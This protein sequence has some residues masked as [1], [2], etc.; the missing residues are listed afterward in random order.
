[1]SAGPAGEVPDFAGAVLCGGQSRR[2]GRDKALIPVEGTP[3]VVRVARALR[4]AG[5]R[6]VVAVGR[7]PGWLA[8]HGLVAVP[9]ARPGQGPAGGVATALGVCHH[10]IVVVAGCDLVAPSPDAMAATV[11]ALASHPG[12]AVAVPRTG[13]WLQWMHAAWRLAAAPAL[14]AALDAGERA[15]GSVVE[16]AG[17]TVV[18]VEGVDPAALADADT[19]DDLR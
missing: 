12:A 14:D 9:D 2:M 10:E 5:A 15:V 17:L 7:H 8:E 18:E 11:A 19:P 4:A 16:A 13:G 3:L 1:M 6:E